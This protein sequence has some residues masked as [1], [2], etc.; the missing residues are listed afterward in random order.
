I[1]DPTASSVTITGLL[2]S[3]P[4]SLYVLAFDGAGNQSPFWASYGA[5][6]TPTTAA[7]GT[8]APAPPAPLVLTGYGLTHASL[9]WQAV[10]DPAG[11]TGYT[12]TRNSLRL[13]SVTGTSLTDTGLDGC[14]NCTYTVQAV[15]AAGNTSAPAPAVSA[16]GGTTGAPTAAITSPS[17]GATISAA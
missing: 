5:A 4:Q 17:G 1:V 11:V 10:S 8:V 13:A 6:A 9:A 7:S 12:V 16:Y 2:A 14:G 15:D 3:M